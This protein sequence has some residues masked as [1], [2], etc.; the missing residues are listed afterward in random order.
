MKR[1]N[2]K[3]NVVLNHEIEVLIRKSERLSN[4]IEDLNISL[5][6]SNL[7]LKEKIEYIT[8]LMSLELVKK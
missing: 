6:N 5:Y 8:S 3:S 4:A 7:D 2:I 1:K